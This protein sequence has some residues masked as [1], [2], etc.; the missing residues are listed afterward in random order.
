MPND[1][2][3]ASI[4]ELLKRRPSSA[5]SKKITFS[6][7]TQQELEQKI[8]DIRVRT[9][10][11][12]AK[13]RAQMLGLPYV[14]LEAFPIGPE[15]LSLIP[16]E[17]SRA[18][19]IIPFLRIED[20]IR[21]GVVEP[22]DTA[23]NGI[24]SQVREAHD[25]SKVS[26]YLISQHSFDMAVKL[27]KGVAKIKTVEYGVKITSAQLKTFQQELLS[28]RILQENMLKANMT[29]AFAM[30]ISMALNQS[31]SDIHIEAEEKDVVVRFRIDG[32]LV[33]MARLPH[34]YWPRLSSR[35]KTIAGLKINVDSIPQDGRITIEFEGEEA[36]DIRVSTLPSAFGESIVFRLLKS[37]SIGLSFEELGMRKVVH[38]KLKA[39]IQKPN[40]MVITTGPTGSGKTTT[41]YAILNTLNN[42][43]TKIITLENPIEYK[44]KGIVQS[45]IDHSKQYTFALGLRSILRQDP[46]IIMV[47]EIRDLEAAQTA[48]DAALTGHL[49]LSTIHTNDASGA[50]PRFLGMGVQGVFLAPALNAVI[51]QRL[52]RRVCTQCKQPYTP[53]FEELQRMQ[54]WVDRIPENSGETK[55]NLSTVT[56]YKGVG[57]DFCNHTGYKGRIGIYEVFTMSAEIEQ[58]ILSG[59]VSEFEM[60]DILHRA[61]M[62]TMGQ[63]G[64]LKVCEGIT[65]ADEVF[66]VAKE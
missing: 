55:P 64:V 15:I 60:K 63:D 48:I 56:F 61:G 11:E 23:I 25:G 39:E 24:I 6:D 26:I 33:D 17:T 7:D 52:V 47:G 50:I 66:R 58:Q 1:N 27:Y 38:D 3:F 14:N 43:D 34:S 30:V 45:Q 32:L 4:D 20:Q 2:Q 59:K 49:M 51:G 42:P 44:L 54:E 9:L 10:E 41:L 65:T 29:D 21:I 13:T 40:G 57:C 19:H 8:E 53:S 18:H 28:A 12:E 37:S 35:I 5:P 36:L 46:D 31:S 16:E 62:L 22:D